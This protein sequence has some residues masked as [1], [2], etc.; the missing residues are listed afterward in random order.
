MPW[1]TSPFSPWGL[2]R[3]RLLEKQLR[4]ELCDEHCKDLCGIHCAAPWTHS[5]PSAAVSKVH[6]FR[7]GPVG[8]R[9]LPPLHLCP[10][11]CLLVAL[12]SGPAGCSVPAGSE[13]CRMSAVSQQ[14]TCAA[15]HIHAVHC[16]L[17]NHSHYLQ[18]RALALLHSLT[19]MQ[20]GERR[21]PRLTCWCLPLCLRALFAVCKKA[22]PPW[23]S[24]PE[25]AAQSL[26]C[27]T[28]SQSPIPMME[29]HSSAKTSSRRDIALHRASTN[30]CLIWESTGC[31]GA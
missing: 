7:V 27:P 26:S 24:A 13:W 6:S 3:D 25:N 12:L 21:W 22:L 2:R 17:C 18:G 4:Q 23:L 14:S 11:Q 28:A 15:A 8:C 5:M 1:S 9:I 19:P 31:C 30:R 20:K 10:Q 29:P 16:A